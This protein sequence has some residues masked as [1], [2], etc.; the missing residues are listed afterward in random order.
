MTIVV[1]LCHHKAEH[2]GAAPHVYGFH[3]ECARHANLFVAALLFVPVLVSRP[4]DE[5]R[6]LRQELSG[7]TEYCEHTRFRLIPS[8]F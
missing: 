7:Y 3:A 1:N 4:L 5:E 2:F 8:V 6:V